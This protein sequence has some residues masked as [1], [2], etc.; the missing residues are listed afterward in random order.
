MEDKMRRVLNAIIQRVR[1]ETGR[2]GGGGEGRGGWGVR[3]GMKQSSMR[4]AV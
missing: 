1:D 2:D 3:V 4:E